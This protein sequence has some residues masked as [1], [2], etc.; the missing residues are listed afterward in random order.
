MYIK[1]YFN[2]CLGTRVRTVVFVVQ[3]RMRIFLVKST[4]SL[5]I[6]SLRCAISKPQLF[7]Q[8][9]NVFRGIIRHAWWTLN[10]N[11]KENSDV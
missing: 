6:P 8:D 9:T 10:L 1:V 7:F 4:V 11:A 2:L 5:N 3:N